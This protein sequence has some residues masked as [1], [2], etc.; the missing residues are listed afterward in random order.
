[1]K[2]YSHFSVS[3]KRNQALKDIIPEEETFYRTLKR[4]IKVRFLSITDCAT[5]LSNLWNPVINH[6]KNVDDQD[7][8]RTLLFNEEEENLEAKTSTEFTALGV[9]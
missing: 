3:A 4:H 1:M 2:T 7:K 5:R 6:F 9:T 8:A